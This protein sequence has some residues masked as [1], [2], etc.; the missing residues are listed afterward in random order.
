[1]TDWEVAFDGGSP[2]TR[3]RILYRLN[4]R[5]KREPGVEYTRFEPGRT[6]PTEIVACVDPT[7][8]LG[9]EYP[10]PVATLVVWWSPRSAGRGQFRIQWYE[11]PD[12][13]RSEEPDPTLPDGYTLS[14]GWHQDDHFETLGEAHFQE[15]YPDGHAERYGVTFGDVTPLWVLSECLDALPARLEQFR[16]RLRSSES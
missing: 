6:A 2:R 13:E 1:M 5:L 8:F 14:C 4:E 12:R 9:R 10:A 3:K 7:R 15:E 16:N 11:S